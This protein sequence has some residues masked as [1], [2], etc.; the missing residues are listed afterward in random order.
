[1]LYDQTKNVKIIL[2]CKCMKEIS[3]KKLVKK[4]GKFF[5]SEI[6]CDVHKKVHG[7]DVFLKR[8]SDNLY[9]AIIDR[10]KERKIFNMEDN[11]FVSMF[12]KQLCQCAVCSNPIYGKNLQNVNN[13]KDSIWEIDY[14]CPKC[15]FVGADKVDTSKIKD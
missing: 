9:E 5:I 1:M 7:K 14:K 2:P 13:L 10:K 12:N 3:K 4:S 11:F 15:E 8:K 6:S